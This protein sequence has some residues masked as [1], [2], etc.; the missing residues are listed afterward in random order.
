VPGGQPVIIQFDALLDVGISQPQP[1]INTV[2][3]S[4]ETGQ[5]YQR[6]AVA[7]IN[8]FALYFP[9]VSRQFND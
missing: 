9:Q 6:T 7:F 1:V 4:D 3:F 2:E 8:G 5:S